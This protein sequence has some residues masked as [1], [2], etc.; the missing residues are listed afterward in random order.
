MSPVR[1]AF[2]D[3]LNMELSK[4]ES[5]FIERE[6]EA[7]TRSCQLREQLEELKDHRRLFH[8]AHPDIQP[9]VSS[10]LHSFPGSNATKRMSRILHFSHQPAHTDDKSPVEGHDTDAAGD[11]GAHRLAGGAKL[12]PDEYLQAR[13]QLK[14]AVSEHYHALEVLNNYRILNITGFRKVLKKFEK[15]SGV[16]VQDLYIQEKVDPCAFASDETVQD[17]LKEMEELF[18]AR[19]SKG[20]RKRALVRLRTAS[21][22]KTHHFSTFRTGLA[23]GLAFPA[24]IDGIVRCESSN[25]P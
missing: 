10:F 6:G 12:D 17:L 5:F 11:S 14:R 13:K 16:L 20:D 25:I 8:D 15:A 24:V 19:F 9:P 1:L 22:F 21:S 7:R 2:F 3:K 23:L 18:T 4:I